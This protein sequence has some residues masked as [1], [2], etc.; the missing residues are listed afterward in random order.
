MED[1]VSVPNDLAVFGEV[2]VFF[3]VVTHGIDPDAEVA[4]DRE[5]A[6]HVLDDFLELVRQG[7]IGQAVDVDR[8]RDYELHR[9]DRAYAV[10]LPPEARPELEGAI[11][12]IRRHVPGEAVIR[13]VR[14]NPVE[15]VV[16]RAGERS[17]ASISPPIIATSSGPETIRWTCG[18]AAAFVRLIQ[19]RGA[20]FRVPVSRNRP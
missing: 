9:V 14:Q 17:H 11:V 16:D 8:D 19:G 18:I 15:L 6:L 1:R 12:R 20:I 5:P 3:Q 10:V 2:G 13:P 4:P 7:R